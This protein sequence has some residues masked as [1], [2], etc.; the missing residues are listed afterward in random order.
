MR[1]LWKMIL[2]SGLVLSLIGIPWAMMSGVLYYDDS[3]EGRGL[4]LGKMEAEPGECL[5][6][7]K[8]KDG[9]VAWVYGRVRATSISKLDDGGYHCTILLDSMEYI[10]PENSTGHQEIVLHPIVFDWKI[11]D[12]E[13]LE[14]NIFVKIR[15]HDDGQYRWFEGLE[16]ENSRMNWYMASFMISSIVLIIGFILVLVPSV[17]VLKGGDVPDKIIAMENVNR[18]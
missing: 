7:E 12:L 5:F 14:P 2:V 17:L 1:K 11:P 6:S 15:I 9:D 3:H 13:D 10:K 8:F 16:I 4:P 18:G